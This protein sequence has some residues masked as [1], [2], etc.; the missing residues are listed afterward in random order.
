MQ[1]A[2]RLI[3][4]APAVPHAGRRV[5]NVAAGSELGDGVQGVDRI[6]VSDFIGTAPALSACRA[7]T[8]APSIRQST[9]SEN[10]SSARV[11]YPPPDSG[12][13]R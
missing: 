2:A 6:G 13:H 4:G 7:R 8:V 10:G 9:A 5:G 12:S 3:W 11:P 1:G